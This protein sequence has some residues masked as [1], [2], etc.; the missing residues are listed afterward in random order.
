MMGRWVI[1][2]SILYLL[3][4][5]VG[6]TGSGLS[7][8][9]LAWANGIYLILGGATAL[10]WYVR[11]YG[12]R[13]A[14]LMFI[15]CSSISYAAEWL[16]TRH[17]GF[18]TG[19]DSD[20]SRFA[21]LLFGVPLAVPFAWCMLLII[22]KAFAPVEPAQDI[23]KGLTPLEKL[24]PGLRQLKL[25]RKRRKRRSFWLPALWTA[26][27]AASMNLLLQPS[28]VQSQPRPWNGGWLSVWSTPDDQTT[29]I[30][31]ICWW[32]T[33]LLIISIINYLHDE[34][35]DQARSAAFSPLF[36]PVMLLLTLES[37]FLTL[38]VQSGL[39][40]SVLLNVSMLALLFLLR[41][42]KAS[43]V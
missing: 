38:A 27:M 11:K 41:R 19:A 31:F 25:E 43:I 18:H 21:P 3:W 20:P 6:L 26:S 29:L 17:A 5:V 10:V 28:G 1:L 42:K 34:Y 8:Q 7:V 2:M 9:W 37:L 33:A 36:V 23:L 30:F 39:W 14:V 40:W 15:I 13:Q 22:A 24:S 12:A 16:G 35:I 4:F 32:F